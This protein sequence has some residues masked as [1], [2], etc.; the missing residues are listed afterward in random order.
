MQSSKRY[1]ILDFI[2]GLAV[3]NMIAYHFLWNLKYLYS[4]NIPWFGTFA[5]HIWQRLI[6]SSFILVSGFCLAL[7][8]HP[9]KRGAI[10]FGAGLLVS[11]VTIFAVPEAIIIF[12]ILTFMGSAMLITGAIRPIFQKIPSLVGLALS[13]ML[14]AVTY[15]VN[16]GYI[17]GIK[18]PDNLYRGMLAT[19]LGFMEEGFY[20]A[21]YF[22]IMPW[23]FLFWAGYF[24][25]GCFNRDRLPNVYIKPINLIGRHALIIYLLHQPLIY[26]C[27][28]LIFN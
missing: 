8:S 26:L 15:Y 2:R 13:F 20:S 28:Y 1:T 17:A 25:S 19:Y 16:S 10:V 12:G 21:D 23:I 7:G 18:L 22:S 11:G 14:F 6:C 24:L 9:F 27:M 3:I 4:I 5:T